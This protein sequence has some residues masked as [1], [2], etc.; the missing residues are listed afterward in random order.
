ME[1]NSVAPAATTAP[2]HADPAP[3]PAAATNTFTVSGTGT[4]PPAP[5]RR[6]RGNFGR[7][8]R[9][10]DIEKQQQQHLLSQRQAQR[11]AGDAESSVMT[12]ATSAVV[13]Q[14]TTMRA[15]D[16]TALTMA[17]PE[18]EAAAPNAQAKRNIPLDMVYSSSAAAVAAAAAAAAATD[19][20]RKRELFG[21]YHDEVADTTKQI[22]FRGEKRRRYCM[23]VGNLQSTRRLVNMKLF[24]HRG[25]KPFKL[26]GKMIRLINLSVSR[27]RV[28]RALLNPDGTQRL[29]SQGHVIEAEFDDDDDD[30]GYE[31]AFSE[32]LLRRMNIDNDNEPNESGATVK[33]GEWEDLE[34]KPATPAAA[35]A[36]T[37]GDGG[38][39]ESPQHRTAPPPPMALGLDDD[40]NDGGA[41]AAAAA[42]DSPS[43]AEQRRAHEAA[44]FPA[45]DFT[46]A[47]TPM[48]T[49]DST[50][51]GSANA[52]GSGVH[53]PAPAFAE[54][55]S[56]ANTTTTNAVTA[57]APSLLTPRTLTTSGSA[58]RR[59]TSTTI[60]SATTTRSSR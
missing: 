42:F 18:D 10:E 56:R 30:D 14:P 11:D 59:R 5:V 25:L 1:A 12:S 41:A 6:G 46:A 33:E 37:N 50:T 43:I 31:E 32:A 34:A 47:G 54:G 36:T 57:A 38:S 9:T 3:A 8:L 55:G 23:I 26:Q 16:G 51:I 21:V 29:D 49:G 24:G 19:D 35:A 48:R 20:P 39:D 15:R 40:G 13:L 22:F 45:E 52:N 28:R 60:L 4:A 44:G 58:R 27:P 53:A 7:Q 2:A 17:S